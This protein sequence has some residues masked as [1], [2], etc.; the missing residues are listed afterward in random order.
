MGDVQPSELV[1]QPATAQLDAVRSGQVSAVELL[2]ATIARYEHHNP[3]LNAVVVERIDDARARA[4]E[5]DTA[6]AAGAE[7]GPLHGLPMTIKEAFDWIGTPTTW[8]YE[9]MVAN[10]A[11]TNATMVQRVLDAGAVIY[12]KTNVPV[13]LADWQSF[14]PVYGT[15]NNPWDLERSPGGSSGGSAASLAAG[16]AALELGSDIGAS[17]RNPAHYCGVFG[18]KPTFELLPMTGHTM[19]GIHPVIDIGVVGPMARSAADLDVALDVLAGPDGL[20]AAGYRTALPAEDRTSLSDFRVGVMLES[21]C[22]V[23]DDEL[24]DVL[25]AAI[26][27]LE[28]AGLQVDWD[29]RP[30]IDDRH[31]HDNYLALLRSAM[32]VF[33][34]DDEFEVHLGHRDRYLAGDRDFRAASGHG[35]TLTYRERWHIA[36]ER[37]NLRRRWAAWFDD[38]DLLLCP[39]AASAAIVHDH[40]GE[41]PERTI[42]VNGG[43]QPGTDQ[44]FWA[45]WSCNVYLPGTVAPAGLT[46]TGLPAGLQIV[47]PHLHDRRSI[48]FAAL[49]ERELGGY[50]VPPG[51]EPLG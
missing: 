31:A 14:N 13:S 27:G 1:L 33:V 45:G 50:Q 39:T 29:A 41:R 8:G 4:A 16:L 22:V 18:H 7:L 10:V 32:G 21:D 30:D 15:S 37:E 12:G 26:E 19:P 43:R 28:A 25:R 17:I 3:A 36:N 2:D 48:A 42:A 49:M 24:T 46:A 34:S 20:A 44:L 38:Y 47:A 6:Q 23:Q 35:T 9:A 5:L 40:E 51:Y 11:T